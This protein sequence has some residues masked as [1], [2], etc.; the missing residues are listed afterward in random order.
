MNIC[1]LAL[2]SSALSIRTFR[3]GLPFGFSHLRPDLVEFFCFCSLILR[4][5]GSV[6]LC[7]VIWIRGMFFVLLLLARREVNG[8]SIGFFLSFVCFLGCCCPNRS[9]VLAFVS[10]VEWM[11]CYWFQRNHLGLPK[12]FAQG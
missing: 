11:D 10:V 5:I 1:V 6:I 4:L 7:S 12:G 3:R 2:I 9:K 8:K